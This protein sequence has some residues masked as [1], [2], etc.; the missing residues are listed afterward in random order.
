[1]NV[2]VK[3]TDAVDGMDQ[4]HLEDS[5]LDYVRE[6]TVDKIPAVAYVTVLMTETG[7][8]ADG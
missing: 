7:K 2:R 6:Y 8:V 1:M 3:F 5:F 4:H